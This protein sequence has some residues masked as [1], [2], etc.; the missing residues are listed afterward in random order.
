MRQRTARVAIAI[1]AILGVLLVADRV[2]GGRQWSNAEQVIVLVALIIG[3]GIA[4]RVW[5][6]G[7]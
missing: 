1:A 7:M 5:R 4:Q 6:A 2:I 3:A